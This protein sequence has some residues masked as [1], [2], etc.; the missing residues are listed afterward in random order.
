MYNTS[1]EKI[2][3]SKYRIITWRDSK[4][5]FYLLVALFTAYVYK[6]F[7]ST[8]YSIKKKKNREQ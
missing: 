3:A 5:V 6:R 1:F 2:I 8:L 7:K 4:D